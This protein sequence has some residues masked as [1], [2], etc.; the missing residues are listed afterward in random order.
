MSADHLK[1]PLFCPGCGSKTLSQSTAKAWSCPKCGFTYF[2]NSAAA[3]AA[4]L[5][6]RGEIL[7]SIRKADPG[8]GMLDLPGGFVDPGE[9]LERALHREI[10]EEL[11]F[12]THRWQYMFSFPNCYEYK[13]IVY[14]TTD[15]FFK[16]ELDEK[17]SIIPCDDVVGIVWTPL[18][19]IDL[20]TLA[21]SSIRTAMDHIKKS[22]QLLGPG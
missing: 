4:I 13:G 20:N 9:S 17:P 1:T 5:I 12:S 19:D 6:H 11:N 18:A 16:T 7:L 14:Q 21:L 10:E 22:P 15:A 8:K 3:V 2:Q